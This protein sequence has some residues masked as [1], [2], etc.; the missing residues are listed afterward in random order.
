MKNKVLHS[1]LSS[2]A[3]VATLLLLMSSCGKKEQCYPIAVYSGTSWGYVDCEG[4]IIIN[5]QFEFATNFNDEIA[6][7]I[8]DGKTG[9]INTLGEFVIKPEY[10]MGTDVSEGLVLVLDG[11]GESRCLDVK[12]N[13]VFSFKEPITIYPFKD[14]FAIYSY[15]PS[16]YGFIDKTGKIVIPA[17]YDSVEDFSEG[18][19]AVKLGD[20]YGYIDNKG[21]VV[22]PFQFMYAGEFHEGMAAVYNGSLWGF[23]DKNGKYVINPQFEETSSFSDG[24]ACV[25]YN[26]KWGY[27]DKSGEFI[28]PAQFDYAIMFTEGYA[29]I[30]QNELYG[31]IN[32]KGKIV[33]EPQ[34]EGM[35]WFNNGLAGVYQNGK[36][37]FIDTKGDFVM[38]PQFDN[39]AVFVGQ[40]E[41]GDLY[42]NTTGCPQ[43]GYQNFIKFK[44]DEKFASWCSEKYMDLF[45]KFIIDSIDQEQFEPEWVTENGSWG[46]AY[47]N[48]DTIPE[49]YIDWA[50][51]KDEYWLDILY[52]KD[53]RVH[54]GE[55]TSLEAYIPYKSLVLISDHYGCINGG[56]YDCVYNYVDGKNEKELVCVETEIDIVDCSIVG[57]TSNGK[58]ISI[59]EGKRL[60]AE[61]YYSMGQSIKF[62]GHPMSYL[63]HQIQLRRE[64]Q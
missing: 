46:I 35:G 37:G 64:K 28:I 55:I 20:K 40:Y 58:K 25:L 59:E 36:I 56:E 23:I 2:V 43:T 62:K 7:V 44:Y 6:K 47:F 45:T 13:E 50:V 1:V 5:P 34:F 17:V 33:I 11:N 12:G 15:N 48:D 61:K 3:L 51:P 60:I 41:D 19:A 52:I 53:G 24:L 30:M 18:L 27:V 22:I 54:M 42:G 9:Y 16:N 14:G 57:H 49:M 4:T 38:R 21:E 31:Y 29:G 39:S 63:I 10:A 26:G 8:V 32:K